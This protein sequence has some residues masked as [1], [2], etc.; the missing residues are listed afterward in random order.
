MHVLDISL[1]GEP[2]EVIMAW[3]RAEDRILLTA[4][5]DFGELL[6]RSGERFPSVIL[7]R[8][9]SRLPH[10]Q[11]LIIRANLDGIVSDLSAGSFVVLTDSTLRVRQLPIPKDNRSQG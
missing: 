11:A 2:D 8:R 6:W 9:H 3:S 5:T 4:D 7:L 10:G 1:Q